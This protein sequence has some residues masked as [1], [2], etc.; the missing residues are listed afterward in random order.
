MVAR[1]ARSSG[2][3][4]WPIRG[5]AYGLPSYTKFLAG[6]FPPDG[7]HRSWGFAMTV[8]SLWGLWNGAELKEDL[9]HLAVNLNLNLLTPVNILFL[10][11]FDRYG[12]AHLIWLTGY[13]LRIYSWDCFIRVSVHFPTAPCRSSPC[14]PVSILV[15]AGEV[16]I[17]LKGMTGIKHGIKGFILE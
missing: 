17:N 2:L 11:E 6:T 7:A 9:R 1:V 5:Q 14:L 16:L 10:V 4:D 3:A 8:Q 15:L 13:S 12:W